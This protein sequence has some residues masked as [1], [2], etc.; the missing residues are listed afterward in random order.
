MKEKSFRF[1]S[2]K[3]PASPPVSG[4]YLLREQNDLFT[5]CEGRRIKKV[6][7]K[8]QNILIIQNTFVGK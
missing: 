3:Y 1:H 5:D 2:F 4:W 8:P 6:Q 7:K